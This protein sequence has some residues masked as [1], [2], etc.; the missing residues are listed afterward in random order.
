MNSISD[1]P[2]L[3]ADAQR[4]L[5]DRASATRQLQLVIANCNAQIERLVAFDES[6][7]NDSRRKA[8]RAEYQGEEGHQSLLADLERLQE[9][10]SE[11]EIELE[12][13]RNEFAILKLEARERI[14]QLELQAA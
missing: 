8:R 5:R 13:L 6:L 9:R 2:E 11:A 3:I 7:T 12:L 10:E 1:Y 4:K 14:A